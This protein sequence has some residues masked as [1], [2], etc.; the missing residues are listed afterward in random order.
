M[1]AYLIYQCSSQELILTRKTQ[2]YLSN[3]KCLVIHKLRIRRCWLLLYGFFWNEWVRHPWPEVF[4]GHSHYQFMRFL[5]T[6]MEAELDQLQCFTTKTCSHTSLRSSGNENEIFGNQFHGF[7]FRAYTRTHKTFKD[8][9]F[10]CNV[11]C[12]LQQFRI[13]TGMI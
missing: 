12:S 7:P 6:F 8:T 10:L 1:S 5:C 11:F 2:A 4:L 9:S 3:R 13:D